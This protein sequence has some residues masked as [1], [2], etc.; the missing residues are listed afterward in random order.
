[1]M[2]PDG[3]LLVAEYGNNRVQRFDQIGKPLGVFGTIGRG[4]G[5]LQYPWGVAGTDDK[6][7]VLD[8]GNNRVQMIRT[9]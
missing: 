1:M 4:P 5:E 7:F 3:T 6:V 9:P 2:L 8:S